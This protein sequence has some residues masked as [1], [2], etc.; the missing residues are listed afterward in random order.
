MST[1]A[2]STSPVN[3]ITKN[4]HPPSSSPVPPSVTRISTPDT[5][6]AS[7]RPPVLQHDPDSPLDQANIQVRNAAIAQ[8]FSR[9]IGLIQGGVPALWS[10]RDHSASILADRIP[11]ITVARM[12][13]YCREQKLSL[14]TISAKVLTDAL[15]TEPGLMELSPDEAAEEGM[16]LIQSMWPQAAFAPRRPPVEEKPLPQHP[17]L[18]KL[19][20][21]GSKW[22]RL[23]LVP[24]DQAKTKGPTQWRAKI[25]SDI[26]FAKAEGLRSGFTRDQI[27]RALESGGDRW[28]WEVPPPAKDYFSDEFGQ[29]PENM[30]EVP[31]ASIS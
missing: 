9:A 10:D 31:L 26:A 14:E 27:M 6:L 5:V 29:I 4:P 1:E 15:A 19:A 18:I 13:V 3:P 17:V 2:K 30:T 20:D 7:P 23:S 8:G 16:P 24:I 22:H 25:L 28:V 11:R 12:I 21:L